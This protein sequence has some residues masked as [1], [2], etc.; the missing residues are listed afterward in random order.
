MG[1]ALGW[2]GHWAGLAPQARRSGRQASAPSSSLKPGSL[3]WPR[4]LLSERDGVQENPN[5]SDLNR[6]LSKLTQQP[7]PACPA[8]PFR[9]CSSRK[10]AEH[11]LHTHWLG[12][13]STGVLLSGVPAASKER[14]GDP[15]QF[16]CPRRPSPAENAPVLQVTLT[17]AIA[18]G[19]LSMVQAPFCSRNVLVSH[20][21]TRRSESH[22]CLMQGLSPVTETCLPPRSQP[23]G[24]RPIL[25]TTSR[26]K[27]HPT[28][29]KFLNLS[30]AHTRDPKQPGSV[31]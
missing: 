5:H 9:S 7:A 25:H 27:M 8:L 15:Q 6:G 2:G 28:D 29:N 20:M 31:P 19:P 11:T 13:D 14:Q 30:S 26:K 10:A 3:R 1:E 18:H 23:S 22:R 21:R 12:S 4:V 24:T 16:I 17:T